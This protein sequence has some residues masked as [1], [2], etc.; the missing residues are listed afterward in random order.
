MESGEVLNGRYELVRRL[1]DSRGLE[2]W[3]GRDLT[4]G[5]DVS[6][7]LLRRRAESRART[8]LAARFQVEAARLA[9]LD[10]SH[11]APLYDY[12]RGTT[13]DGP[14][15]YV[16]S[17]LV[18]G[19]TLAEETKEALPT[20]PQVL[21]FTVQILHALHAAHSRDVAHLDLNPANIV[22]E[23]S[24]NVKVVD[25]GVARLDDTRAGADL[26]TESLI[27][28][29]PEQAAAGDLDRS[30]DVYALGCVMY[31]MLTGAAPFG[32]GDEQGGRP[33]RAIDAV[34][35]PPSTFRPAVPAEVDQLVLR[36]L[37]K[38]P[39]DRPRSAEAVL[40][41]L[42]RFMVEAFPDP[43]F[44]SPASAEGD[45]DVTV[46]KNAL[47]QVASDTYRSVRAEMLDTENSRE[48]DPVSGTGMVLFQA[49]QSMSSPP[50][51]PEPYDADEDAAPAAATLDEALA[52]LFLRLGP[53]PESA[54][55]EIQPVGSDGGGAQG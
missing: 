31:E 48:V 35:E 3:A 40:G 50:P 23:D 21:S 54:E 32:Q 13:S 10:E 18:H 27:S 17:K 44:S 22:I 33:R 43:G 26:D 7:R 14:V 53:P 16:V 36:L 45:V 5:Q 9:A 46:L 25:F 19:R 28:A 39:K 37:A 11:I 52:R 49:Q 2:V 6:I 24:G 15:E 4:R 51:S 30:V 42:R 29:I 34:P 47:Q 41:L 12:R 55:R 1:E 8:E 38:D 20:L